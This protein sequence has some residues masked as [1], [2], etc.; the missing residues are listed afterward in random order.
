MK[1]I[2]ILVLLPVKLSIKP[3]EN[4][5]LIDILLL[6][7]TTFVVITVW[8]QFLDHMKKKS[9]VFFSIFNPVLESLGFNSP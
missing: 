7:F 5:C 8:V 6:I 3:E 1:M 2:P 9:N 4:D